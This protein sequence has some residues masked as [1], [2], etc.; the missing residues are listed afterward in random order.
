LSRRG[1]LPWLLALVVAGSLVIAVPAVPAGAS[2]SLT[3]SG[4]LTWTWRA[5]PARGCAAAGLCGV[6]GSIE[7]VPSL[8]SVA[9]SDGRSVSVMLRDPGAVARV[10]DDPSGSCVDLV[11]VDASL[12]SGP[13]GPLHVET[14]G[15]GDGS[16]LPSSGR[17]AGPTAQDLGLSK[18]PVRRL[19]G[20]G[21]DFSTTTSFAA[22]PFELTLVST[23][24]GRRGAPASPFG[25][26]DPG[27][28]SAAITAGR[29]ATTK[30]RASRPPPARLARAQHPQL[31]EFAEVEYRLTRVTGS[32]SAGF[33]G[34]PPP[35]CDALDACA[36]TGVLT[37]RPHAGYGTLDF[38]GYATV[39]KRVGAAV[40]L[41][42]L[43]SRSLSSG[44]TSFDG[45][46]PAGLTEML[47]R[48][49]RAACGQSRSQRDLVLSADYPR[50]TLSLSPPEVP[51]AESV[52][53]RCPGPSRADILGDRALAQARFPLRR[54]G[55]KTLTVALGNPG[56]FEG[57][58]YAGARRGALVLTF[59]RILLRAGTTANTSVLPGFPG[60]P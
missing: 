43:R 49:G 17:C 26:A 45:A 10:E 11:P 7:V 5:D 6:S 19:R 4:S 8:D 25:A 28:R 12:S 23:L 50:A 14:G 58:A 2:R 56:K 51:V 21:Y 20:G 32:L 41:A 57:L 18:L 33:R 36:S 48:P 44:D 52:R 15:F 22:G 24:R 46:L 47:M 29:T 55:R 1:R 37:F 60:F 42:D 9:E 3:L 13:G 59:R 34:L 31:Y 53:T 40:A 27:R 54:V 35:L 16:A 38:N 30:L 39:S